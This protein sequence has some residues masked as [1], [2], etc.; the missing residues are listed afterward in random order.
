MSIK[1]LAIERITKQLENLGCQ[2]KIITEDGAEFGTLEVAPEPKQTREHNRY[3]NATNYKELL[4]DIKPGESV[5][6]PAG[7][8]PIDGVQSVCSSFMIQQF[9]KGTY[10]TAQNA[11]R[12]GVEVLRLE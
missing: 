2:F 7:T 10:M 3:V 11:D 12:N 1:N 4:K 8:A 6:V 9:G 5:F